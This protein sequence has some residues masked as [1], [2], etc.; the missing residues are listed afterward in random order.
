M[1]EAI[2]TV[3]LDEPREVLEGTGMRY[4][5]QLINPTHGQLLW[6]IDDNAASKLTQG[7]R[8]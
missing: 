5:A 4:P 8:I 7:S 6:F 1:A 3:L 2:Q